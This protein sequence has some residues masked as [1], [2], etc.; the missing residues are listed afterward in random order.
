MLKSMPSVMSLSTKSSP[1][2][3]WRFVLSKTF[4]WQTLA[5][6]VL[7]QHTSS[8]AAQPQLEIALQPKVTLI[9]G[10]VLL[11]DIASLS[12]V[13]QEML[14]S[15]R[16][17]SLGN[18][19]RP[20][21]STSL[22]RS[23]IER[24]LRPRLAG[25]HLELRWTGAQRVEIDAATQL[26]SGKILA[27]HARR[28]MEEWLKTRA[29]RSDIAE[30]GSVPDIS[31]P[32]GTV[33]LNV[34]PLADGTMPARRMRIWIDVLIDQQFIRAVAVNFDVSAYRPAYVAR[35]D[36]AASSVA[37]RDDFEQREINV[38]NGAKSEV[39]PAQ[40]EVSSWR[41]KQSLLKGEAL[42]QGKVSS[43]PD[44]MRGQAAI[45]RTQNG[46]VV[47]ESKVEVLQD[48]FTGQ[49]VKVRPSA[50]SGDVVARVVGSG[51]VELM[52]Q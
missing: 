10:Q 51:V 22:D 3:S 45:L 25:H 13:D 38:A 35:R 33:Q 30:V 12:G 27:S 52:A 7:V 40:V 16:K 15:L 11:G 6:F 50:S 36:L 17:I 32:P 23:Q 19:P 46:L 1:R 9:R 18:V 44:V 41:M 24:W 47:L 31:L 4:L 37:K 39:V 14:T 29:D 2:F 28:A 42:T 26:L 48:G 49:S 21:L 5:M 34:R 20:G 43:V 8:P